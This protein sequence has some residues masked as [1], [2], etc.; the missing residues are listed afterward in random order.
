LIFQNLRHILGLDFTEEKAAKLISEVDISKN[1]QISYADFL[2]QFQIGQEK[3]LLT[4]SPN[5]TKE[6]DVFEIA[7]MEMKKISS[8]RMNS[9]EKI[10]GSPRKIQ[11]ARESSMS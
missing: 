6:T 7:E 4:F 5:L 9:S 3:L 2:Q 1:G 10:E 11:S 8:Y